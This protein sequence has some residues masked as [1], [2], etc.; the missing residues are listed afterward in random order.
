MAQEV[1]STFF[2]GTE[3]SST[4][5][6]GDSDVVFTVPANHDAEL[7]F[8]HI[9]S[10]AGT[11]SVNIKVFH[12]D[13]STYTYV[14]RNFTMQNNSSHNVVDGSRIYLHAGDKVTAY[15]TGGSFDVTV[16]GR[17]FYNIVRR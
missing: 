5:P 6:N 1:Y 16:S 3:V 4:L 7:D 11:N 10:G 9:A 8:V 13:T 15:K 2:E 12:A 14:L 17:L